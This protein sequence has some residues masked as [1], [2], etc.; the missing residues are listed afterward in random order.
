MSIS[1]RIQQLTTSVPPLELHPVLLA[2]CAGNLC[3]TD[4]YKKLT[5]SQFANW[6]TRGLN[7]SVNKSIQGLQ[8]FKKSFRTIIELQMLFFK[9][10]CDGL[11]GELSSLQVDQF[12]IWI[13]LSWF[14]IKS[15]RQFWALPPVT[16]L[17]PSRFFLMPVS[18]L[19]GWIFPYAL[20]ILSIAHISKNPG[21]VMMSTRSDIKFLIVF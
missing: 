15:S 21:A 17:H 20:S 4:Q 2:V 11:V 12:P 19:H 14:D 16:L 13:T 8:I 10:F 9:H 7:S 6:L 5:V 1:G 3:F 18:S